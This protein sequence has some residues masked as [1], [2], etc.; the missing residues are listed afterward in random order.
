MGCPKTL[1][2]FWA[3]F[4]APYKN[5]I[6]LTIL[7]ILFSNNL[8]YLK[9]NKIDI[10]GYK[11]TNLKFMNRFIWINV[12]LMF[13]LVMVE[14][15]N[16]DYMKVWLLFPIIV[17]PVNYFMIKYG[18]KLNYIDLKKHTLQK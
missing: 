11:F 1:V 9:K 12:A 2:E 4:I 3:E 10:Q 17:L 6:A 15:L 13:I 7:I 8:I 14:I 5:E 18:A 16:N